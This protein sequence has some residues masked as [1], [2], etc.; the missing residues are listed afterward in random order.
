MIP[1]SK[2]RPLSLMSN[3]QIFLLHITFLTLSPTLSLLLLSSISTLSSFFF[4]ERRMR[5][6]LPRT[7]TLTLQ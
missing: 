4:W 5:V 2:V 1:P 3:N 7:H 6:S